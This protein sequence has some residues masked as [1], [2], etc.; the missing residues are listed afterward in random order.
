MKRG[1]LSSLATLFA[2]ILFGFSYAET[3]RAETLR[4]GGTGYGLGVMKILG[5]TFEKSCPGVK[6]R[7]IP[8]L[9][10][11][12]GIKALSH[13]A[14][15]IAISGR[16]LKDSESGK[17]IYTKALAK[18]PF[19]FIVNKKVAK[20]G[21]T[22]EE[23]EKI[24]RGEIEKWPDGTH[25]RPVL[26]PETDTVTKTVRQLS[27]GMH[28]AVTLAMSKQGMILAITDQE[29]TE[30]VENIPG[31]LAAGTLTQILSENRQVGVLSFNGIKPSVKSIS[32]GSYPLSIPLYLVIPD[33][34]GKIS[35]EFLAF[36]YSDSG[37]KILTDNGNLVVGNPMRGA[38]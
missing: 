34:I 20:E 6:I 13:G 27:S 2:V 24:F 3:V 10:S 31:A 9:G 35:K 23:L 33:K 21:I 14:L 19:I 12:G 22:L 17:G 26:R 30:I 4:I 36:I 28:Q 11:T 7:V 8:S 29:S 38:Q 25:I 18:T 37:R 5:E 15:D 32:N 1:K 16:L